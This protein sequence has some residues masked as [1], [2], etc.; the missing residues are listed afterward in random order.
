MTKRDRRARVAQALWIVWAVV[1]WCVVFDHTVEIAGRAYLHA[2]AL[3]EQSGE[4]YARIDD[5]MRPAAT[6]GLWIATISA[7]A[8]L[9]VGLGGVSV[10][11]ATSRQDV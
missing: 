2:A 6:R 3:A 9:I 1:V 8:I 11:S 4:P 5:W 10:A 7:A